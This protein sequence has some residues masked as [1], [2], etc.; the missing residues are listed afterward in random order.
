M[1]EHS[2]YWQTQDYFEVPKKRATVERLRKQRIAS[3]DF[4]MQFPPKHYPRIFLDSRLKTR[5]FM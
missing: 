1:F 4:L 3:N 5:L 2:S